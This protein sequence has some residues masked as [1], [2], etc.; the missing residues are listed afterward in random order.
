[1]LWS[2]QHASLLQS[3]NMKYRFHLIDDDF[4]GIR[5]V[6][7]FAGNCLGG[8]IRRC[9]WSTPLIIFPSADGL[10]RS[11]CVYAIAHHQWGWRYLHGFSAAAEGFLF[12]L[13]KAAAAAAA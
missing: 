10:A 3:G 11:S 8:E 2:M 12:F 1:M 5:H 7:Y 13:D 6:R 9:G 4:M